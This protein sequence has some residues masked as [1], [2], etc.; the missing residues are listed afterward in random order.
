MRVGRAVRE[1]LIDS[2]RVADV[3]QKFIRDF[4]LAQVADLVLIELHAGMCATQ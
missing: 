3:M 4:K 1:L 2:A